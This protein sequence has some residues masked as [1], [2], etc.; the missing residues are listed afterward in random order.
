VIGALILV[1]WG[2]A[3]L[4]NY[5]PFILPTPPAVAERMWAMLM[6][7]SL[8]GHWLTTLLEAGLGFLLA[9]MLALTLGYLIA[10][11]PIVDRVIS[12]YIGLSQGLPVV[13]LAPLLAIWFQDDL[14]RKVV[15]V[16]LICFIPMLINTVV[17]LRGLDR[18]LLEVARISGASW[19]QTVRYVELPLG[20][21]PLLGGIKLGLTL[22][23]TGAIVGEFVT[24]DSGLGFLLTLGRG[25]FDTTLV[26]VGLVNLALLTMLL[27]SLVTLME[28]RVE[29]WE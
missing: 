27:Y 18:S 28:R 2:V 24:A 1:W 29:T 25:N 21:R 4:G 19:W 10:K 5:P 26:F 6:D 12:P 13:A 9:L 16:A 17:A 11:S 23:V 7:R 20:A 3:V 22:S 15:I 14:T 8:L